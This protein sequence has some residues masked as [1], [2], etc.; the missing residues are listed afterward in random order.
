MFPSSGPSASSI[1]PPSSS[2]LQV[3]P[4]PNLIPDEGYASVIAELTRDI[5]SLRQASDVLLEEI[6]K[7]EIL[8]DFYIQKEDLTQQRKLHIDNGVSILG[9]KIHPWGSS[10]TGPPPSNLIDPTQRTFH[11]PMIPGSHLGSPFVDAVSVPKPPPTQDLGRTAG[12]SS[13]G[14]LASMQHTHTQHSH[15]HNHHPHSQH[16]SS[17]LARTPSSLLSQQHQIKPLIFHQFQP[18][19]QANPPLGSHIELD[20]PEMLYQSLDETLRSGPLSIFSVSNLIPTQLPISADDHSYL[21]LSRVGHFGSS[22]PSPS[23]PSSPH[24]PGPGYDGYV[25]SPR[26]P[27]A[28]VWVA[29]SVLSAQQPTSQGSSSHSESPQQTEPEPALIESSD[30]LESRKRKNG[31]EIVGRC[32]K[33]DRPLAHLHLHGYNDPNNLCSIEIVCPTCD[34]A[35][36]GPDGPDAP[37]LSN[38]SQDSKR[39]KKRPKRRGSTDSSVLDC[40]VCK[41][42][43]AYG[44]IH[45]ISLDT[46]STK[47]FAKLGNINSDPSASS[48]DPDGAI[49]EQPT[50]TVVPPVGA[51][52]TDVLS[53]TEIICISCN[54]K[55]RLCTD[56]GGG[57]KWRTGKWRPVEMFMK[58]RKTCSLQHG[59]VGNIPADSNLCILPAQSSPDSPFVTRDIIE[60]YE[61]TILNT[62]GTPAILENCVHFPTY[63]SIQNR[64]KELISEIRQQL[65]DPVSHDKIRYLITWTG[66]MNKARKLKRGSSSALLNSADAGSGGDGGRSSGSPQTAA[67]VAVGAV[68]ERR[69][70]CFQ[71][72]TVCLKNQCAEVSLGEDLRSD[73]TYSNFHRVTMYQLLQYALRDLA[74]R[75]LPPIK[76][77]WLPTRS[78]ATYYG[79]WLNALLKVGFIPCEE[80][81]EARRAE[82]IHLEP[83][84]FV[85]ASLPPSIAP[86]FRS[87]VIKIEDYLVP[88][89]KDPK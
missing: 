84:W 47:K 55:Y 74:S 44:T 62:L 41:R 56:C 65:D 61:N 79:P 2:S 12:Y 43:I 71:I 57:G 15:T 77:V 9:S 4:H 52:I 89:D 17:S 54:K 31:V 67:S 8:L 51:F 37:D 21:D 38:A 86:Q 82:G 83:E 78:S 42:H 23:D 10:A 53:K 64:I 72:L 60:M 19:G 26:K 3:T 40:Y 70:L 29:A 13:D 73:P 49:F 22:L 18:S 76:Y 59:R 14:P 45:A 30:V 35:S 20:A 80:F 7:K 1:T 63:A 88:S 69:I 5:T 50:K 28:A 16:G 36:A 34:A 68:T 58:G 66:H 85:D 87:Y 6:K 32:K 39:L 27:D 33:C 46:P 11:N 81:I 25:P 75:N 48:D 24:P